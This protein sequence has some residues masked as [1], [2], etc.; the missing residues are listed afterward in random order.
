MPQAGHE[1]VRPPRSAH[2]A[3]VSAE[4]I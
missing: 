2:L 4:E 1:D 3:G